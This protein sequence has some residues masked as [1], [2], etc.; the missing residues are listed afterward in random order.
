[1]MLAACCQ[2]NNEEGTK[3]YKS[4]DGEL[5]L[6]SCVYRWQMA[7]KGLVNF[8]NGT[9]LLDFWYEEVGLWI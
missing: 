5:L 1:M 4:G 7:T 3:A 8:R 9:W 2:K 6:C